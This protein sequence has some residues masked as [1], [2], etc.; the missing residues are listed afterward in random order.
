MRAAIS[1]VGRTS[2]GADYVVVEVTHAGTDMD[3]G[4]DE[5]S[6]FAQ[7]RVFVVGIADGRV[8]RWVS[9]QTSHSYSRRVMGMADDEEID[10]E[11]L[12]IEVSFTQTATIE[13]DGITI[14]EADIGRVVGEIDRPERPPAGTWNLWEFPHS[15]R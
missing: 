2:T 15:G 6:S 1:D 5:E 9:F 14:E 3:M 10:H 12:P 11:G 7:S 8:A 4:V 13:G